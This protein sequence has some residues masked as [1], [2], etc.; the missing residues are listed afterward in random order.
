MTESRISI[1]GKYRGRLFWKIPPVFRN[2]PSYQKKISLIFTVNVRQAKSLHSNRLKKKTRRRQGWSCRVSWCQLNQINLKK[3]FPYI[4]P[5]NLELKTRFYCFWFYSQVSDSRM[6]NQESRLNPPFWSSLRHA[7]HIRIRSN[8]ILLTC[9]PPHY[10]RFWEM[11]SLPRQSNL[12]PI[13]ANL[14]KTGEVLTLI[15]AHTLVQTVQY[16]YK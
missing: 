7:I 12:N 6:E 14:R 3:V 5:K 15:L 16:I 11:Q 9:Q 4:F 13:T 2:N 8:R 10:K 1:Q